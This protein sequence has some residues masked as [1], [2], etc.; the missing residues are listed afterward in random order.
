MPRLMRSLSIAVVLAACTAGPTGAPDHP[1]SVRVVNDGATALLDLHVVT[2]EDVPAITRSSLTGG[3]ST[4]PVRVRV[5]HEFPFVRAVAGTQDLLL[6][7]VE[8][9]SGFNPPLP[10]GD[11]VIRLR[12]S[13][14]AQL[15]MRVVPE[16]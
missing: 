13:G 15:D 4:P 7:P 5:V 10:P 9:F 14:G 3:A 16:G 6:H 1:Y 12:Y 8:G 11:Y 2:G